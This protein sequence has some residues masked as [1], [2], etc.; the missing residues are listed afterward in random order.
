[1]KLLVTS[2]IH[3]DKQKNAESSNLC[4]HIREYVTQHPN[5]EIIFAILGDVSQ[6]LLKLQNYL[7]EFSSLEIPKLFVAGNHDIWLQTI[8]DNSPYTS[9]N[10]F[11]IYT[12][13]LPDICK[14][15]GFQYLDQNPFV[16]NRV[17]IVGNIGWYDFSFFSPLEP[18]SSKPLT[19]VRRSTNEEFSWTEITYEDLVK[20]E[21]WNSD[22]H[23]KPIRIC[24]WNDLF[25]VKWPSGIDDVEFCH[26]CYKTINQQ[27]QE[28]DSTIDHLVFLSHHVLFED[29]IYRYSS[30]EKEFY[31]AYRG[32][33]FL[34]D[35]VLTHPKLRKILCGHT[36]HPGV[37]KITKTI[38]AVNLFYDADQPFKVVSM[39]F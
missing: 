2:D 27:F 1:M 4:K 32:C 25:Y 26:I 5:E 24:A 16:S 14:N 8:S 10:S 11:E 35:F 20:K 33:K 6:N 29:C 17:G 31:N 23:H 18:S 38:E 13:I 30:Y 37:Y 12:S 34:G 28:I 3:I 21:L 36:H 7:A 9:L 15:T 22:A 19:F 39:S